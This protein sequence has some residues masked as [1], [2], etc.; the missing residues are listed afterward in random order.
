MKLDRL[1]EL[2]RGPLADVINRVGSNEKLIVEVI[3]DKRI[4]IT[5]QDTPTFWQAFAVLA[6][7]LV[8]TFG[9]AFLVFYTGESNVIVQYAKGHLSITVTGFAALWLLATWIAVKLLAYV[10]KS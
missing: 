6:L 7:M 2:V 3:K 8:L 1:S 4:V 5:K 9:L 10:R